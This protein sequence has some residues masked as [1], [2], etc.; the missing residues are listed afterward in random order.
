M[1]II[2]EYNTDSNE[3]TYRG[4]LL[5]TYDALLVLEACRHRVIPEVKRR[6]NSQQ[7]DKIVPYMVYAWDETA[8]GMKRWTDGKNWLASRVQGHFLTYRELDND[9]NVKPQGLIKQSFSVTTKQKHRLHIIAYALLAADLPQQHPTHPQMRLQL[10]PRQKLQLPPPLSTNPCGIAVPP[11]IKQPTYDPQ[12]AGILPDPAVYPES[13]LQLPSAVAGPS[14][15][16]VP[17]AH[18]FHHPAYIPRQPHVMYLAPH[19]QWLPLP[20]QGESPKMA[21][22]NIS[23]L[24]PVPMVLR[25][26]AQLSPALMQTMPPMQT[27]PTMQSMQPPLQHMHPMQ[28][29]HHMPYPGSVPG[30]P[31]IASQP[32][33]PV[34]V[35]GL[36]L[37]PPPPPQPAASGAAGAVTS[38][39]SLP[40]LGA[41]PAYM[42]FG[43]ARPVSVNRTKN[44]ESALKALDKS[45]THT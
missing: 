3:V 42:H 31:P 28:H 22:H 20:Y 9:R 33:Y 44:D 25:P 41:I 6:L 11:T 43:Q 27:M 38:S 4:A 26:Q 1:H 15:S 10:F 45:F 30:P 35:P 2:P 32:V 21:P 23:P 40:S 16:S 36:L 24:P 34:Q 39:T 17:A 14:S 5:T 29:M 19:V 7:R 12:F 37:P 18:Q 8:C 13:V